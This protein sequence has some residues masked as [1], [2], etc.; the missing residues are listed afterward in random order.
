MTIK[1]VKRRSRKQKEFINTIVF[2][3]VTVLS[4]GGVI[5]YLWIYTAVDETLYAIEIQQ[6]TLGE[7]QNDII[8]LTSEI[9]YLKRPDIVAD[10][11]ARELGMVPAQPES[12]TIELPAFMAEIHD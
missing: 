8:E 2:F 10:R 5:A 11:A 6:S 1:K 3:L 7:I 12:L 4:I 9:E